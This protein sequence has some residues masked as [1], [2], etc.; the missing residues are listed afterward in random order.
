[1]SAEPDP[2]LVRL[3]V[4][5]FV[6]GYPLVYNLT[7]ISGYIGGTGHLPIHAPLND[8][9]HARMLA[10]HDAKFVSVNNDTLCSVAMCDVRSEP[11]ILHVPDTQDRYYVLQFVDAWTNNFAYIGRRATGTAAADFLLTGPGYDGVV[12][13]GMPIVRAPSG[14]FVIVGRIAVH[15]AADV[16]AVHAL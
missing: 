1:M 4:Q 8:F 10:D 9:G 16:P 14:V 12:P 2:D 6:Y 11:V 13:D 15:G 3:A 5:T 7:E